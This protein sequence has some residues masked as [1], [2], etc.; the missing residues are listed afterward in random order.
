MLSGHMQRLCLRRRAPFR[1]AGL[2]VSAS[3]AALTVKSRKRAIDDFRADGVKDTGSVL[4]R[5]KHVLY[6]HSA[7]SPC[8]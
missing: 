3:V 4:V 7:A 2:P 5:V 8:R 6:K 1:V